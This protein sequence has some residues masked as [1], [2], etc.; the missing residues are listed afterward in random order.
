MIVSIEILS[1]FFGVA[2]VLIIGLIILIK[3]RESDR[4][5]DQ[6]KLKDNV[7][8]KSTDDNMQLRVSAGRC[9]CE[10]RTGTQSVCRQNRVIK[11]R[12]IKII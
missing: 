3:N 1:I 10:A 11:Y 12:P 2:T 9:E 6:L 5:E 8:A 4:L 7:I